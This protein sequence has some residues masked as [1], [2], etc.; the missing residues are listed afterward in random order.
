MMCNTAA[1]QVNVG[2]GDARMVD[3]WRLANALGP[4][5]IASFA[6]SPFGDGVPSGWQSSRLRAW[7]PLD[8]TRSAPV[9]IDDDP[10]TRG[11]STRSTPG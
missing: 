3:R 4:T 11:P 5:L 8:P 6:N 2:L 7:W 1:I 10:E 9:G